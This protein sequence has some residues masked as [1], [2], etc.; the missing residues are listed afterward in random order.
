[1]PVTTSTLRACHAGEAGG[2]FLDDAALE[3]A[4]L[5]EVDLGLA[6][7]DAVRRERCGFL[8]DERRVQQCFRRDAADVQAYAAECR[9][10]FDEHRLHAEVGGA[11]RGR[12]AAGAGAE[13]EHVAFDVG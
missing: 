4:Q 12:V 1:M 3:V 6:E 8:D 13:H 10:A 5:V 2:Q 9:I 7:R 11:E